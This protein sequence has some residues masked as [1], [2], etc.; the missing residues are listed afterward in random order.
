MIIIRVNFNK[1]NDTRNALIGIW[2]GPPP[3]VQ[4]G[5][6]HA[7]STSNGRPELSPVSGFCE[8][9]RISLF[10]STIAEDGSSPA[11]I[12]GNE[13]TTFSM[14]S[15]FPVLSSVVKLGGTTE[16]SASSYVWDGAFFIP[17]SF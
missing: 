8:P 6:A 14:L 15:W 16:F 2:F 17:P 5:C 13:C 9:E 3:A 7:E 1:R 11:V 12:W 4:R 10:P